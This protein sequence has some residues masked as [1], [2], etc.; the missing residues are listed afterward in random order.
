MPDR[1]IGGFGPHWPEFTHFAAGA[2]DAAI[3]VEIADPKAWPMRDALSAILFSAL[4]AEAFINDLPEAASRDAHGIR[5]LQLTAAPLLDHLAAILNA[6]EQTHERIQP[7]Y[8]A[9]RKL[10]TGRAFDHA[11]APVSRLQRPHEAEE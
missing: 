10:L 4:A 5:D 8:D 7:K 1:P 9:A 3:Q 11:A 6:M 2:R